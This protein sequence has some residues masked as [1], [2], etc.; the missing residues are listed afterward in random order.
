MSTT[1]SSRSTTSTPTRPTRRS[2]RAVTADDRGER[3]DAYI[4]RH[5]N[6]ALAALIGFNQR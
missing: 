5:R 4:D 1:A 6:V 3:T 2:R